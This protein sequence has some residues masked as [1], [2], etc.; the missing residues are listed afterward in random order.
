MKE[1]K[2][3][4][5]IVDDVPENITILKNLLGTEYKLKAA[6]SGKKALEI[7]KQKPQPD[8][9]LLDVMMPEMDGYE[10]CKILKSSEDTKDISI[11]FQTSNNTPLDE[12]KAF[13]LGAS[14]FI[15]KPFEPEVVKSRIKTRVR[16]L[17]ERKKLEKQ[18]QTLN[19]AKALPISEKEIE[20]LIALGETN[21]I[22]FKSTLRKNLYTQKNEARIENQCLKTVV[23]YLNC[24]G[25][26][27]LVGIDDDGKALG[28]TADNFKN[29]DKLLLHWFNLLKETVG[30]DLIKF[31]ESEILNYKGE[32]ILFVKCDSAPKP[33]FFSRDDEEYFYV[34]VG[35]STQSLKPREMLAY[36]DNH[37]G[38]DR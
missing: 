4:I 33:V 7:A 32:Q 18:L 27:L 21:E 24:K 19:D 22:E 36:I 11:I 26:Y 31:I 23:G 3:S 2:V 35:N 10:V 9:I 29:N 6:V 15:T 37:Y 13:E 12:Q 8:L 20:Q 25:G 16:V 28:L 14:D 30:A 38:S 34:R 5:L 1:D 17:E